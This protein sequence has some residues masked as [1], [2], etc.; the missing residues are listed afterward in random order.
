MEIFVV[1]YL[2]NYKFI[3]QIIDKTGAI[4]DINIVL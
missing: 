4:D 3:Y 2:Q 1:V